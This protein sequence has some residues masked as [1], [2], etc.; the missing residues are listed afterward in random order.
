M[1]KRILV[2]GNSGA[3]KTTLSLKLAEK[4]SLPVYHLD[5]LWWLPGWKTD[6]RENFD[7]KLA[8]ILHQDS[9]IIDGPDRGRSNG[10]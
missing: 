7:R 6:T 5:R 9:W 1:R 4:L 2:F 3:G 10:A 8:E